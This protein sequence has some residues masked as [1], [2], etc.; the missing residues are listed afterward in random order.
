MSFASDITVVIVTFNSASV[1]RQCLESL[2]GIERLIVVDKASKD[3][4]V[5]IAHESCPQAQIVVNEANSGFGRACNQGLQRAHTS[6]V[7]FL[8]PD[9]TLEPGFV[10]AMALAVQR[11]PGASLFGPEVRNANGI[12]AITFDNCRIARRG[13]RQRPAL[14]ELIPEAD[15]CV[16]F[17]LGAALLGRT[18]FLRAVGGFDPA[19]FLFYEDDDLCLRV[20]QSGHSIVYVPTARACHLYGMS[21]RADRATSAFKAWHMA[22]SRLYVVRKHRGTFAAWTEGLMRIAFNALG[23]VITALRGEGDAC[24]MHWSRVRGSCAFLV[25]RGARTHFGD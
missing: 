13:S 25:G 7:L 4:T 8:N 5:R 11:Y 21:S 9:A 12:P 15:C 10:N 17:L 6:F 16:E 22:W 20:R 19:L 2:Y 24:A 3:D 18:E 14:A 1:I 23:S